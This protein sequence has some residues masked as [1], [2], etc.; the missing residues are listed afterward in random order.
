[1]RVSDFN[2]EKTNAWQWCSDEFNF[3]PNPGPLNFGLGPQSFCLMGPAYS[4]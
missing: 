1:M 2:Y 3:P 4:W